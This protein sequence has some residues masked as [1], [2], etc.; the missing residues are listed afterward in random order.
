MPGRETF[1]LIEMV[2]LV[3]WLKSSCTNYVSPQYL[4][5]IV[6]AIAPV[7]IVIMVPTTAL[8]NIWSCTFSSSGRSE[9]L[10][11]TASAAQYLEGVSGLSPFPLMMAIAAA[12]SELSGLNKLECCPQGLDTL[13]G[14]L[15]VTGAV[16]YGSEL[17]HQHFTANGVYSGNT[18]SSPL[19]F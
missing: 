11:P 19:C 6:L 8:K 1:G 5:W 10:A 12:G 17:H 18:H 3:S 13:P 16:L 7:K 4:L 14:A 15:E 2:I 9:H